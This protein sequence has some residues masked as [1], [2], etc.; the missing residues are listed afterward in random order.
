[1]SR[2]SETALLIVEDEGLVA[3]EM[4]EFLTREG[5]R[6]FEPVPTGEEAIDRCGTSPRPDLVLMDVHLAGKIDGIDAARRIRD[7]FPI[8][9]IIITACD[10]NRTGVRLKD[11]APESYLVKPFTSTELLAALSLVLQSNSRKPG[12]CAEE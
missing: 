9:V 11:L 1:V 8:P 4:M 10:D 3:L 5:Y 6:V 2:K 7:R 12:F